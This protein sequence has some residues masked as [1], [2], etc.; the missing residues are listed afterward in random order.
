MKCSVC[1]Y[2]CVTP[3]PHGTCSQCG[4]VL[5]TGGAPRGR[6][7]KKRPDPVV[8]VEEDTGPKPRRKA[9]KKRKRSDG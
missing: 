4:E 8:T 5:P 6:S 2:E 1:R 9:A 3:G 7:A